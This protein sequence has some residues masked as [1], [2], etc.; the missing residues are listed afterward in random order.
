MEDQVPES[1]EGLQFLYIEMDRG[2]V[3]FKISHFPP[4]TG[5]ELLRQYGEYVASNDPAFRTR[6]TLLVL[7][8]ASEVVGDNE[9]P[10][11]GADVV[12]TS[13]D[14][15]D[16]I[17]TLFNA[18]LGYNGIRTDPAE[19][20]RRRWEVAGEDMAAS[21]LAAVKELIGPALTIASKG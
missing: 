19:T 11:N 8:H 16:D 5:W 21:F 13:L 1:I 3:K 18:V 20:D 6:F 4:L 14:S 17:E 7:S 12:N 2:R 10:L 15:W 9:M